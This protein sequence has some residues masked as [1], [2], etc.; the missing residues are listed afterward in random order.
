M[1]S[2]AIKD[3][4]HL[5]FA[6]VYL[7]VYVDWESLG[8]RER[9]RAMERNEED[10]GRER[11]VQFRRVEREQ[12]GVGRRKEREKKGN[13]KREGREREKRIASRVKQAS[14]QSSQVS[15]D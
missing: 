12:E 13:E 11:E 14:E 8:S 5:A 4:P 9:E 2:H 6:F 3:R 15:R 7:V 1:A 10:R